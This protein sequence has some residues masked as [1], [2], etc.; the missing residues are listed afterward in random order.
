M[1]AREAVLTEPQVATYGRR[2]PKTISATT[3]EVVHTQ[4]SVVAKKARI[5]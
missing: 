4:P 5:L 2:L 3:N 1:R